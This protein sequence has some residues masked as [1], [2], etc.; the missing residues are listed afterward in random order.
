M[1]TINP[2]L[3]HATLSA[4]SQISNPLMPKEELKLNDK[5]TA[6]QTQAGNT[7]VT[8]SETAKQLNSADNTVSAEQQVRNVNDTENQ[9][10]ESQQM[11]SG[12]TYAAL[13]K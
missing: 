2:V 6:S 4:Q 3:A 10:L 11:D 1:S 5:S 9:T 13:Q 12:L 7:T 8:L